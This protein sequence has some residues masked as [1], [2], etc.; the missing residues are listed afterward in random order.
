MRESSATPAGALWKS[1]RACFYRNEFVFV[2]MNDKEEFAFE[3]ADPVS[4][5]DF[6]ESVDPSIHIWRE[7]RIP[8]QP[9]FPEII[10][11]LKVVLLEYFKARGRRHCRET[12]HSGIFRGYANRRSAPSTESQKHYPVRIYVRRVE[13]PIEH[14]VK[15]PGPPCHVKVA[16]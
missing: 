2:A 11:D 9:S 8:D 13:Y 1:S 6:E 15:V 7:V 10:H 3:L 5:L 12:V 4:R 14:R 16:A